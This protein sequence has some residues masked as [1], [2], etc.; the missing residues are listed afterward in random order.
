MVWRIVQ[1][2]FQPEVRAK[3]VFAEKDYLKTLS[4]YMDISVLPP[5]VYPQGTGSAARGFPPQFD[6]GLIP[7]GYV[8]RDYKVGGGGGGGGGDDCCSTAGR[9]VQT[10]RSRDSASWSSDDDDEPSSLSSTSNR[11]GCYNNNNISRRDRVAVFSRSLIQGALMLSDCGTEYVL[12]IES[13]QS[14]SNLHESFC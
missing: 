2:F 7:A 4:K 1:N 12:D 13:T 5:S 6:G 8:D 14:V 10:Y 9:T 3:I 11:S